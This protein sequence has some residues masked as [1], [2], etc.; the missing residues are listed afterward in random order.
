MTRSP[1]YTEALFSEKRTEIF[2]KSAYF[3]KILRIE[4]YLFGQGLG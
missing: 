2:L 3:L 1:I 4:D